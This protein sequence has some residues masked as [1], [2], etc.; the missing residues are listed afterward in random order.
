MFLR[1]ISLID[2]DIHRLRKL[3][4]LVDDLDVRAT[5]D[6]NAFN[7]FGD[8]S[9]CLQRIGQYTVHKIRLTITNPKL[10]GKKGCRL[11]ILVHK[12]KG[13]YIQCLLYSVGEEPTYPSGVCYEIINRRLQEWEQTAEIPEEPPF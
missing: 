8:L 1:P 10:Q 12:E 5:A 3:T 13:V 4:S 6:S 9:G 11:W 7:E 2:S